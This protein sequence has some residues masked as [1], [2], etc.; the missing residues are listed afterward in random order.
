MVPAYKIVGDVIRILKSD[1]A[2]SQVA[3]GFSYG[4]PA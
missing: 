3:A 1:I 2:P 4:M